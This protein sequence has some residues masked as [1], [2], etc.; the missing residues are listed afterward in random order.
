MGLDIYI[1]KHE[2]EPRT[3]EERWADDS[4][5]NI[6]STT[7]PDHLFKI[8]YFR[9]SY[10]NAGINAYVNRL[11][12]KPGLYHIFPEGNDD[13]GFFRPDWAG[14]RARALEMAGAI[15]DISASEPS[16]VYAIYET[17]GDHHGWYVTALKIVAETC[18]YVLAQDNPDQF[19]MRWSR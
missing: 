1:S 18:G 11:L 8:G 16:V 10:N 9:S 17:G 15:E 19:W 3:D 5:I 7:Q 4:T 2:S 13:S 14:A 12:C 6:D